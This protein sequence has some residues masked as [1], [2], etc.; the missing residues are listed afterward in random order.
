MCEVELVITLAI[1]A[2]F[3]HVSVG[4]ADPFGYDLHH[5]PARHLH[6]DI[7]NVWC[8]QYILVCA[9]AHGIESKRS[10][11]IPC[12]HLTA[13]IIPMQSIHI[14]HIHAVHNLTKPI[15]RFPWL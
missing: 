11:D 13:V 10:E 9:W 6:A 2:N 8:S 7:W 4:I 3:L 15:L 14:I 1:E 12:R 5:L